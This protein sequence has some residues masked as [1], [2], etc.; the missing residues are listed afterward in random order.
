MNG[1]SKTGLVIAFAVVLVLF[2]FLSGGMVI[3]G[4]MGGGVLGSDQMGWGWGRMGGGMMGG[5]GWMWLPTLLTLG[6]GVMLGWAIW[7]KK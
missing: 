1:I 5:I 4:M 6:L 7:A 2:L 3:G